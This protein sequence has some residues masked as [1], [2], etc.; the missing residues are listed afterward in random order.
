MNK[1]IHD[2]FLQICK[3]ANSQICKLVHYRIL[4]LIL[5]PLGGLG[6]YAQP[7]EWDWAING[8]SNLAGYDYWR[9][10]AEQVYDIVVG[11]DD[12]YYFLASMNGKAS[13]TASG[14]QLAGQP[15]TEYNRHIGGPIDI[16]LFSTTCDGQVRWSQAIGGGGGGRGEK[17]GLKRKK[18]GKGGENLSSGRK[19]GIYPL[20]G[21]FKP[22][23]TFA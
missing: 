23:E 11:S 21:H 5:F 1:T 15:V 7:Y 12:N 19:G 18:K 16:F 4:F 20:P 8:G 13:N 22:N 6:G 10:D 2:T 9:Y 14:S 3:S 17:K